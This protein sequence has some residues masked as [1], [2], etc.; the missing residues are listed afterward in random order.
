[1]NP[2]FIR[3]FDGS[4]KQLGSMIKPLIINPEIPGSIP[5]SALGFFSSGELFLCMYDLD[6][7]VVYEFQCSLSNFY[8]R[9]LHSTDHRLGETLQLF[10]APICSPE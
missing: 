6:V 8:P 3:T 1:M 10:Y 7:L 2:P 9:S 4:S 5:S